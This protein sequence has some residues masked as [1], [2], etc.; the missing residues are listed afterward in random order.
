MKKRGEDG[1]E[2]KKEKEKEKGRLDDDYGVRSTIGEYG[3]KKN[4]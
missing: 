4:R 2:R 3:R 1:G